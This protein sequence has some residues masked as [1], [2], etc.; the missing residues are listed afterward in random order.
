V[1]LEPQPQPHGQLTDTKR[2]SCPHAPWTPGVSRIPN[3]RRLRIPHRLRMQESAGLDRPAHS[4]CGLIYSLR[5]YLSARPRLAG[6]AGV[7]APGFHGPTDTATHLDRAESLERW[8]GGTRDAVRKK[9]AFTTSSGKLTIVG[10]SAR[11]GIAVFRPVSA[12]NRTTHFYS[13]SLCC[14]AQ[15]AHLHTLFPAITGVRSKRPPGSGSP[16][17]S[18]GA[19][20]TAIHTILHRNTPQ[21][22]QTTARHPQRAFTF[23][24]HKIIIVRQAAARF[25]TRPVLI[26][27]AALVPTC[28]TTVDSANRRGSRCPPPGPPPPRPSDVDVLQLFRGR[29]ISPFGKKGSTT[30]KLRLPLHAAPGPV[31][32]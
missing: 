5:L 28:D 30:G 21:Q 6:A 10:R 20:M 1:A 19:A 29:L 13:T 18:Q 8:L 23:P 16:R 11:L 17:G 14:G 31:R 4:E 7:C 9:I 24:Q 32:V 2:P 22:P 3:R 25:W 12:I 15:R 27:Q 26:G